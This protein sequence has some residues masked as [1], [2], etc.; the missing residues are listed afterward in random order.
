M[1]VFIVQTMMSYSDVVNALHE[2]D[3]DTSVNEP[4]DVLILSQTIQDSAEI[5]MITDPDDTEKMNVIP[6][7][8]RVLD[9]IAVEEDCC[10]SC[11]KPMLPAETDYVNGYCDECGLSWTDNKIWYECYVLETKDSAEGQD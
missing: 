3:L 11:K 6:L 9:W 8:H 2:I 4:E 1:N 10:P 5:M 7:M